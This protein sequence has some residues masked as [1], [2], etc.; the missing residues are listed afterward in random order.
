MEDRGTLT[1]LLRR[2][3]GYPGVGLRILDR[4]GVERW[5]PW[6]AIHDGA[7]RVAGGLRKLGVRRGDRVALVFPTCPA[8]F[9]AFFGVLLAG[10]IPV[11]LYPPVRLGRLEEYEQRTSRM[12]SSVGARLVLADPRVRRLLG[13]AVALAR[14]PLG[15]LVPAD[16]ESEPWDGEDVLPGDVALIQFS[17]GTTREP[18]GVALSHRA[19]VAQ[20]VTLNRFWPDTPEVTHSGVSWLPLYHDMG[21]IGCIF[22]ALERPGTLTLLPPEVFVASP[23]TWLRAISAYRATISPAPNFAY[24]HCLRRVTDADMAGVDLSS[25]RVALNGAECVVPDVAR[26]FQRRFAAWGFRPEALTPVYGLSEASLA[27]TFSDPARP[28]VSRRF[29]RARLAAGAG[30]VRESPDGREIASVGCPIPGVAL[31][32][33][34]AAGQPVP[35]AVIGE[36]ECRGPSVMEGYVGDADAT[37]EALRN[38][39][40]H[41]GDL[42]FVFEGELYLT[43]RAKDM[44]LLRG[45]NYAPEEVEHAVAGVAGARPGVAVA[46]TWLPEGAEGERLLVLVEA[47]RGAPESEFDRIAC[48]CE[49]RIL[50]ATGLS[51]DHVAVLPAGS[52]PRTSSGKLRRQAAL[53]QHLAG[54]LGPPAPVTRLRLAAAVLRSAVA[55]LRARLS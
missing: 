11:P 54:T 38:G 46:A 1:G 7:R 8:F 18:R 19:V 14:P 3:A 49:A 48:E 5:L 32:I 55:F 4:Q 30:P 50:A 28:F 17:S 27:V 20:A 39:W 45:R 34:D 33:V 40:L 37:S 22:P 24:S 52:L 41:T 47:V 25:W 35:P 42:G 29:D 21:L 9:D 23:A 43:G 51:A 31:R 6:P 13:E 12:L 10:A 44:L 26:A 36:V 15:C 16:V 2:V 53:A